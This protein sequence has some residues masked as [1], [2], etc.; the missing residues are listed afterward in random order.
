MRSPI[1]TLPDLRNFAFGGTSA[2]LEVLLPRMTTPL[3]ETLRIEFVDQLSFALPHLLQFLNTIGNLR[4]G[5]ATFTLDERISVLLYLHAVAR[6]ALLSIEV[7]CEHRVWQIASA[8][9]IINALRMVFSS[10]RYLVLEHTNSDSMSP[11]LTDEADRSQWH[12]LLRSFSN[13]K[14][15]HIPGELIWALSCSLESDDED[16]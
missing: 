14:V 11:E 2:Y 16:G 6:M 3:L 5:R 12:E 15:L 4:F 8:A 1:I 7:S 13:L 9:Q 10:V